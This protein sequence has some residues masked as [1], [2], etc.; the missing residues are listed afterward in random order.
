MTRVE[1]NGSAFNPIMA[2]FITAGARLMLATAEAL[3]TNNNGTFAYCDTDS[4]MVSSPHAHIIQEFFQSLNPYAVAVPMF[5]IE[6][7]C[8]GKLDNVSFYG[9]S[10]KRYAL[11]DIDE[12][13]GQVMLRK[14]SAHGLGHLQNI[15][16]E[17][18]WKEILMLHYGANQLQ[19]VTRNYASKFAYSQLTINRYN[20]LDRFKEFNKDKPFHKQIK[21]FNFITLGTGYRQSHDSKDPIIP[22]LPFVSPKRAKEIPFLPFVDYKSGTIYPNNDSLDSESYWKPLSQVFDDYVQHSESKSEGGIGI[23]RRRFV[24]VSR[25]SIRY[26]GKE[27][28]ELDE[29]QV[30]GVALES[31][32]EYRDL[33]TKLKGIIA[34]TPCEHAYKLGI[35]E[36]HLRYLKRKLR[37]NIS[38]RLKTRTIQRILSNAAKA[39]LN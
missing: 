12:T 39:A 5:K 9:I 25:D 32:T 2:T 13:T 30:L 23:L 7:D 19:R 18:W 21:P 6:E 8:Y 37:R 31:Y 28:N 34:S 22:M 16:E 20:V 3:I 11:Y 35:S 29:N 38:L 1:T 24:E 33:D 15:D 4:V 27:S 26:I 14:Y 10:A 36:R 17:Q